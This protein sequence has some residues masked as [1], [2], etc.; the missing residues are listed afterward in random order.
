MA[1]KKSTDRKPAG[2]RKDRKP[3][4]MTP[5]TGAANPADRKL[6]RPG[7]NQEDRLDE[8]LEES[9]PSS[10]PPSTRIE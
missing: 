8:A 10:D 1:K 6:G 9:F 2:R 4:P 5:A 7:R 3:G